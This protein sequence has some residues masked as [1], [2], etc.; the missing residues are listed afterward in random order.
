MTGIK[1]QELLAPTLQRVEKPSVMAQ[2]S[3]IMKAKNTQN[4][5][6]SALIEL[7]AR[8][9]TAYENSKQIDGKLKTQTD[10]KNLMK[11]WSREERLND[12]SALKSELKKTEASLPNKKPRSRDW[13]R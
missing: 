10:S 2:L 5:E 13:N 1:Q 12:Y 7:R 6:P 3:Q 8:F 4:T 9:H 11:Y